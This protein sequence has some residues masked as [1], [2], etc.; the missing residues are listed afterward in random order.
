[1]FVIQY[2]DDGFRIGIL[3]KEGNKYASVVCRDG[4]SITVKKFPAD[5]DSLFDYLDYPVEKAIKK[6]LA[7]GKK[8]GITK[9]AKEL[10]KA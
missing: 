5:D 7:A 2:Y 4:N 3:A 1:M 6:Y 9:A 10:L 8:Y